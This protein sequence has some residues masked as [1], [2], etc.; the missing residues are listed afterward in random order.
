M[1]A[2]MLDVPVALLAE[3]QRLGHDLFDEMWEG[4]LH[5]VP[6]PAPSTTRG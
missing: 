2:V 6:H 1:R 5:M 3:R 4:E